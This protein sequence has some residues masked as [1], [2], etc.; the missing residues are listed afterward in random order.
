MKVCK[1]KLLN[2]CDVLCSGIVL[3][4]NS[5]FGTYK[6]KSMGMND[7]RVGCPSCKP[8]EVNDE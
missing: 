3:D 7:N 6:L 2:L 1:L 8:I 5:L 4:E